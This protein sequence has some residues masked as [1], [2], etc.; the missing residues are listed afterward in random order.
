MTKFTYSA[1][2]IH[3]V[4]TTTKLTLKVYG[5]LVIVSAYIIL[6]WVWQTVELEG[7]DPDPRRGHSATFSSI[8]IPSI[9]VF[10]GVLEFNKFTDEL[11]I[12]N[13]KKKVCKKVVCVKDKPPALA[14][15]SASIIKNNMFVIG[16]LKG[17]K[18]VNNEVYIFDIILCEWKKMKNPLLEPRYCHVSIVFGS[19]ILIMGGIRFK[20]KKEP[21]DEESQ[22]IDNQSKGSTVASSISEGEVADIEQHKSK[23]IEMKIIDV[24]YTGNTFN[25]FVEGKSLKDELNSLIDLDVEIKKEKKLFKQS[26]FKALKKHEASV[27]VDPKYF[28]GEIPMHFQLPVSVPLECNQITVK[29]DLQTIREK[30]DKWSPI[31]FPAQPI[32]ILTG[33]TTKSC[34]QY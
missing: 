30:A 11:L 33:A 5:V 24:L 19:C 28:I 2:G 18:E 23:T 20:T 22:D 17:A 10:G 14:W 3:S 7:Y 12:M 6:D 4:G 34:K 21:Q 9:I 31:R 15:H 16:G 27:K 32:P 25:S 26:R 8:P 13:L 29:E 1:D